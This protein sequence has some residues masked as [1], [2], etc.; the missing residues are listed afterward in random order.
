MATMKA[1][2]KKCNNQSNSGSTAP[3]INLLLFSRLWF[4]GSSCSE[5]GPPA[6][7]ERASNLKPQQEV[8]SGSKP[9]QLRRLQTALRKLENKHVY[10]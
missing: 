4:T 5:P 6:C 8:I 1:D 10:G 7:C 2:K 9:L 3:Q